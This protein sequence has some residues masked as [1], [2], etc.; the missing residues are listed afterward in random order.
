MVRVDN[1]RHLPAL[2]RIHAPLL[3]STPSSPDLRRWRVHVVFQQARPFL[4]WHAH[5]R[6]DVEGGHQSAVA[7]YPLGPLL[8]V[9]TIALVVY[10]V[11]VLL[12]GRAVHVNLSP[13]TAR[14]VLWVG[15]GRARP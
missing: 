10:A 3:F 11:V 9:A 12:S 15:L 8:F 6:L 4:R 2:A 13:G 7:V 14:L 5:I 1:P